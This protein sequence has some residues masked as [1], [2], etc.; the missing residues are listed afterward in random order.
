MGSTKDWL[1]VTAEMFYFISA[2]TIWE[3]FGK[4]LG[5][6]G[7]GLPATKPAITV[8]MVAGFLYGFFETFGLRAFQRPMVAL[9]IFLIAG[10]AIV[11]WLRLKSTNKRESTSELSL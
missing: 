5:Y 10:L 4:F 11:G 3:S 8:L 2:L 9:T 1:H 7:A 6:K